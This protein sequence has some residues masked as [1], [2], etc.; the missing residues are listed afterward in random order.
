MRLERVVRIRLR[1]PEGRRGAGT[2]FLVAPGLVLTAAHLLRTR[3]GR[4]RT[5]TVDRHPATVRWLRYDEAVDA[6]LLH[7]PALAD[8]PTTGPQRWGDLATS[9]PGHPV[10]AY[11]FP[12]FQLLPG[13][14][15]RAGEH[16]AGRISPGS[17]AAARRWEVLSG[18]P[19][20]APHPEDEDSAWAGMSGAPVFSGDLLLGV[21]RRDRRAAAGSRLTVTRSSELLSDDA[22]RAALRGA[23][24]GG[25]QP[26]TEPADLAALLEPAVPERDLRSPAMLLRAD[27]EATPFRGRREEWR[28]LSDWC[29]DAGR[30]GLSVRVLTGP[31]GQGK[32]RLARELVEAV[33]LTPGWVGGLLRADLG[34]ETWQGGGPSG[35]TAAALDG[36]AVCARDLLLVVD[37]A[38]SR[39]RWI[40]RLVERLRPAAAA[41]RTVRLLLVARSSGGWQLDPY[42]VSAATHE[43]LASALSSELGPL[44]VTSEDRRDA[45]RAAVRGLAELLGHTTGPEGYDW[46]AV[47]DRVAPPA[48]LA[49][50]RYATALNVQMEA[51]VALLQA[52]PEPLDAVPGEAVEATLLRHEERYWARAFAG[53]GPP[54]PMPLVRRIVAAATLCGAADEDEAIAVL[55]RVPGLGGEAARAHAWEYAEAL[56][57]L[58]PAA[59]EAYWGS[60]QPDRVAE[61]QASLLVTE[62]PALLP[63]LTARATPAQQIQAM[64]VLTRSVV[65][66]ANGGRTG[67]RDA[68]LER[69]GGLVD[70]PD[71]GTEVLRS[72]AVALP[73]S[74]DALAHFAGRLTGRLVER[75][76][77][78]GGDPAALAW[79]LEQSAEATSTLGDWRQ[80]LAASEESVA[81]RRA[82][83]R[84]PRTAYERRL[85]EG[86][87]QLANLRR[88]A[89]RASDGLPLAEEAVELCRSVVRAEPDAARPALGRALTALA[90]VY[91][92]MARRSDALRVAEEAVRVR[93]AL[94]DED[95]VYE[96][97]WVVSLRLLASCQTE[98]GAIEEGTR[99]A[100]AA[101]AVQRRLTR[102]NPDAH[103]EGLAR[104]LKDVSWH[105]W[106][107][108]L[109]EARSLDASEEAV[110]LLR[111]LAVGNPDSH[112]DSLAHALVNLAASQPA[113]EAL[114]SLDEA[115]AIDRRLFRR[116]PWHDDNLRLLH[117]N[118]AAFL[119]ELSREAEA[120]EALTVAVGLGRELYRDHAL[121]YGLQHAKDLERLARYQHDTLQRT[122]EPLAAVEEAGAIRR[123]LA[124]LHPDPDPYETGRAFSCYLRSWYLWASG[125]LAEAAEAS[126]EGIALYERRLSS[127]GEVPLLDHITCLDHAALLKEETGHGA[128]ALAERYRIV[129][130]VRPLAAEGPEGRRRLA[131]HLWRTA[132]LAE[133]TGGVRDRLAA[134]P[135]I[136]EA[137]EVYTRLRP[138]RV[139]AWDEDLTDAAGTWIRL[140]EGTGRRS[141]AAAVRHRYGLHDA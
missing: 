93:Q 28:Q 30:G 84:T 11:G 118:R 58:Y 88:W 67:W 108:G 13:G 42:D 23:S 115:L 43:I 89:D 16:L 136:R 6:A 132:S 87:M 114:V 25:R 2:G 110:V 4:R 125:R 64:T 65:A 8:A 133:R 39:P 103:L 1:D 57:R 77:E 44:D 46:T 96:A 22:F 137:A 55:A 131:D 10:E 120:I 14:R 116:L 127:G 54:L 106:Q 124:E 50:S 92:D 95:P 21:V 53:S 9:R 51:L 112:D 81:L 33:A 5:A 105:Y 79:A 140:L 104:T 122:E 34:D 119:W 135:L 78:E 82:L 37:Y 129:G 117:A 72:C 111:R 15:E 102:E 45:F 66:H 24:V 40:R 68:T 36:L 63:A 126:A 90:R 138:D 134:L 100:E 123:F 61:F 59:H 41:G 86:M 20:P 69:L 38:E 101:L 12:R 56:R 94:A 98:T 7:V 62:V 18:D 27:V 73:P 83:P 130:M 70:G 29:L 97:G 32:S 75:Y 74:S 80:A 48:D 85:A 99:T 52:G 109:D 91:A 121:A 17:G 128:A 141:E 31:G 47:A 35:A 71:L 19:L 49:G 113:A 60:L 3:D 139:R 76:R 107:A 26:V